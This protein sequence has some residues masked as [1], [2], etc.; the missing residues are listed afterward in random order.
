MFPPSVLCCL[1]L[2]ITAAP[3]RGTNS[4]Q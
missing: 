2:L 1:A 4:Q 3:L